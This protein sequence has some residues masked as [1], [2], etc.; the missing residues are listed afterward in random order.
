M[1][2]GEASVPDVAGRD[3]VVGHVGRVERGDVLVV[4]MPHESITREGAHAMRSELVRL[5]GHDEFGLIFT[6]RDGG[7]AKLSGEDLEELGVVYVGSPGCCP[8][9]GSDEVV[10]EA[11]GEHR[12][13][14]GRCGHR[15][16]RYHP[17]RAA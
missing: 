8:S 9:C 1:G 10:V 12:R 2:W 11:G 16:S 7:V 6:G 15:W 17:G 14:C 13:R 5:V 4:S 3:L